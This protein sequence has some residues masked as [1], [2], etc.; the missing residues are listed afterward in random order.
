MFHSSKAEVWEAMKKIIGASNFNIKGTG[1]LN[2][3]QATFKQTV[4]KGSVQGDP[5]ILIEKGKEKETAENK[6]DSSEGILERILR[7]AEKNEGTNV[8][9]LYSEY[10]RKCL[11]KGLTVEWSAKEAYDYFSGRIGV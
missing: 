8:R 6:F 4:S 1:I 10:I 2:K 11:G 9:F 7:E 3:T 5:V